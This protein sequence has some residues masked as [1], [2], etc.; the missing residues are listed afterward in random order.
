MGGNV[1]H[2]HLKHPF[3]FTSDYSDSSLAPPAAA[4]VKGVGDTPNPDKGLCP[5][6]SCYLHCLLRSMG[7]RNYQ[8]NS[9]SRQR[10]A[11]SAFLLFALFAVAG[12]VKGIIRVTPNFGNGLRPLHSFESRY[13]SCGACSPGICIG[14][15]DPW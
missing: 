7:E 2:F 8:G 14:Y 11:F 3:S 1:K 13:Y 5:L 15:S 10:T 4:K 12:T 9:E 6:H